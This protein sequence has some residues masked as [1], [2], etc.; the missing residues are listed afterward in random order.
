[1]QMQL[2]IKIKTLSRVLG[3]RSALGSPFGVRAYSGGFLPVRRGFQ[4]RAVLQT[5]GLDAQVFRNLRLLRR[6]GSSQ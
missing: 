1:M 5:N 3:A 4:T 6:Q 2:S